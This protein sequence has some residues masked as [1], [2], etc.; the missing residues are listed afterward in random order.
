MPCPVAILAGGASRRFGSDKARVSVNHQPL[1]L[2]NLK[3]LSK[4]FLPVWIIGPAVDTYADLGLACIPD[5]KPHCGPMAGVITALKHCEQTRGPRVCAIVACDTLLTPANVQTLA[6]LTKGFPPHAAVVAPHVDNHWQPVFAAYHT[7]AQPLLSESLSQ[8]QPSL[9]RWL[10]QAGSKAI[11]ATN[12][13]LPASFNTPD[14][15][16]QQATAKQK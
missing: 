13:T 2:Q 5:P 14:E 4:T 9:S 10:N 7:R 3:Q 15:L 16:K 8:D 6:Q 11:R 1:I 12:I